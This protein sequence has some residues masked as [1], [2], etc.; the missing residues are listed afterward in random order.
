[1][2]GVFGRLTCRWMLRDG[3]SSVAVRG[4]HPITPSL[5]TSAL[6][7]SK[8]ILA[9]CIVTHVTSAHS[10]DLHVTS[11]AHRIKVSFLDFNKAHAKNS[12][13]VCQ[14]FSVNKSKPATAKRLKQLEEMGQPFLP[15]T[16]PLE[17]T[18]EKFDE[19]EAAFHK[20]PREPL[21]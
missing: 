7:G 11:S 8:Y 1:M 10:W 20:E 2:L 15:L 19:Y 6:H 21:E 18:I 16:R 13:V 12:L 3:L 17:F 5:H 9:S 14:I 4:T